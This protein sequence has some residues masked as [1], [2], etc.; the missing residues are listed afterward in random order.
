MSN[1]EIILFGVG[2]LFSYVI[3]RNVRNNAI[4]APK[5]QSLSNLESQIK[6]TEVV[7][8]LE[9]AKTSF[10]KQKWIN[11]AKTR[12]FGSAEQEQATY[13]N[14]MTSCMVHLN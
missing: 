6:E 10:C 8:K 9:D 7:E 5:P 12:K 1:R 2:F 3:L 4:I 14:F 11:F 13:D